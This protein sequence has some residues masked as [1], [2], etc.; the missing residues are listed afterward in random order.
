MKKFTFIKKASVFGLLFILSSILLAQKNPFSVKA[1]KDTVVNKAGLK[2][3]N[4]KGLQVTRSFLRNTGFQTAQNSI[5]NSLSS[6]KVSNFRIDNTIEV[7][8]DKESGLPIFIS[9]P[10]ENSNSRLESVEDIKSASFSYLENISAITKIKDASQAFEINKIEKDDIGKTHVKLYQK[11]KGIKVYAS[12]IVVHFNASNRAEKFNGNYNLV[13]KELDINPAITPTEAITKVVSDIS[14]KTKYYELTTAQKE[15]L[16]Y[17]GPQVDTVIYK[18]NSLIKS[19]VLAYHISIRPNFLENWDYF[20]NA[21][22]GKIV[23]RFK[24]TCHVD[25]PRTANALDLNGVNRSINTYQEGS[26]YLLAD[27]SKPMFNNT[28]KTGIILTLDANSTFG[29]NFKYKTISSTNNTW[30]SKTAVSA[31][32]NAGVAYDYFKNTHNRNSIDGKG[33]T[34]Y[35]YVNVVDPENGSAYDNAFWNGSAIFYGNGNTGFKP[36]AGSLDVAGHEMTH[37]VI[38]NSANLKYEG[39]SGAINESMADIFGCMM[40]STDWLIGEDVVKISAFPSGALRSLS[41]PHNGGGSGFQPR[42]MSEKYIGN[43]DNGG[44]HYNSG[45]PNWAFF[46]LAVAINS[47]YRSSK[48]FYR[49]LTNYL[50]ASSQFIDLRIAVIQSAKDLYGNSSNEATQAALAFNAVGITDGTATNN[51]STLETNAGTPY[52]L[53]YDTDASNNNGLYRSS[54]LG[55]NFDALLNKSVGNKPSITDDG[56]VCVFVGKD[57]KLYS[58]NINPSKSLNLTTIQDEPI[59][60]SVAISKDGNRLAAITL[61]KDTSIYVYDFGKAEWA[62]FSLYNP[63][64]TQGVKS[65]GPVYADAIEWSYDGESLVYDC[66]NKIPNADGTT[67]EYW[68]I[69]SIQVWDNALNDF[70]KGDIFKLFNN[71]EEGESIGN[72]VF[73]KNSPY[74]LAFDYINSNTG[75]YAVVGIDVEKN[76]LAVIALNNT[77]GYPS[78]DKLDSKVAFTTLDNLDN[79]DI[80]YVTLNEDKISSSGIDT[81]L[82]DNATWAVY[83]TLGTRNISTGVVE[84]ELNAEQSIQIY[85]NPFSDFISISTQNDLKENQIEL[86]DNVGKVYIKHGFVSPNY[87]LNTST[88]PA[89]IYILKVTDGFRSKAFKVVK[90]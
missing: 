21:K 78:F 8:A 1:H 69:N 73:S 24:N 40:D 3:K 75:D 57:N 53:S 42:T 11:Y 2:A 15:M 62:R 84:N 39:E 7:I 80:N 17:D 56:E 10:N 65:V 41:D 5:S 79:F 49:A 31:H 23:H 32:Y 6:S 60:S 43:D 38:Q 77:I 51:S 89:G 88:L 81:K 30:T 50:T 47:R 36:L 27:A 64:F 28:K 16:A 26:S 22:T 44:V 48:I 66:F 54:P 67:I 74:V 71:L 20:V 45:I 63:T 9:T 55:S 70:A 72:P 85:P 90:I 29:N 68:D 52:L 34:I 58:I 13:N 76:D 82:I 14:S 86:I 18:D 35:S 19:Y 37:G 46:K 12:E 59:W 87:Q 33:S 4:I 61:D 83:Y 25:G